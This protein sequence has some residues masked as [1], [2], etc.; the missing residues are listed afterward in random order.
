MMEPIRFHTD[1]YRRDALERAAE[2]Y[3]A[4]ARV[5]VADTGAHLVVDFEPLVENGGGEAL[6]AEFCNQ[7]FA[8][9]VRCL[10]AGS[11]GRAAAAAGAAPSLSN[12]PPWELLRPYGEGA[13]LGL[14]WQIESL[15]P[16]RQGAATLVLRHGE[17]GTARVALRRNSGAPL[18][19]AYTDQLDFLLMNGGGGREQTDE[20]IGRVLV[21]LAQKLRE[22][23][24]EQP[25]GDTAAAALLPHAEA[26]APRVLVPSQTEEDGAAVVAERIAPRV[27]LAAGRI[28]FDLEETGLSRL[29]LYDA[30]LDLAERGFVFL[31]RGEGAEIRVAVRPRG[32]AS[33]DA[34]KVLVRDATRALN[35]VARG[36][37]AGFAPSLQADGLPPLLPQRVDIDALVADLDAADWQ[38]LG[39]G[40]EPERGPGHQNLRV[41]N[42]L[43]TGACNSDCLFCCEK[44]NPGN[45]LM[46]SA[47][48][49]RQLIL[50]ADGQYDMLFFAS[51][52]P[53]IHPKLFD[54]VE[55][56]K[57]VGF[58]SFGMSSH[59]RSFVDPAFT[60]RILR[61]GF[62]FFD[63]SL[64]AA[65]ADGQL[66][67]NP[68]DD[69]G[70]SLAEALKGL[71]ILYQLADA[72][73]L[74]I[75]VTH[76]IVVSRLN[77]T[78]LEEIFHATYDRGVRH[79]ILQPAR[80]L[81]LSPERQRA[82]EIAEDE[83]MPHL[84]E[85]LRRT[86]GLG[87]MLKPYGFS[88]LRLH[89]GANVELEQNRIKNVMGKAKTPRGKLDL[90]HVREERPR[91]GRFYVDLFSPSDA[92][93]A[94][95]ADG[96]AP[97]LDEA[98]RRGAA[99]PFGCRMGSC[100][101]CCARLLSG[102]VDQSTGIFLSEEQQEQGFVL[103]CQARP[104]SDVT[105]K[106]C[107][108]EEIDPL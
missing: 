35:R 23:G 79:F 101:M 48:A 70:A 56:A 26:S 87:A 55:L 64:H 44:F 31:E 37:A 41:M 97:I 81:G 100:G 17:H 82:L 27:D 106:I 74:R 65:D 36:A 3:R 40:H 33:T 84:N 107:T 68:I 34:L 1:F 58:T 19:V 91:D 60:L 47:D 10:R 38:T 52:E 73:S 12:D 43:G 50:G 92:H 72:L 94:F 102:E 86:E 78:Q 67:V 42:I 95:A 66:A 45:R 105:V 11:S 46:P 80:T 14:G 30:V 25:R 104:L 108:D 83:I 57:S 59:F 77:V 32:D 7:V 5:A 85:L 49:T 22:R 63:I 54:Y 15:S 21:G 24:G 16:V 4:R 28:D 13:A 20:S 103:L 93:M 69:G 88:R 8:E 51:G 89:A 29:A 18:G 90:P 76:K 39:L 71:A 9:T 6:R 99:V 96:K 75:S 62:E 61:A 2:E 53:T 98:L